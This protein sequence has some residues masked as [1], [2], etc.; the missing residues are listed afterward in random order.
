M[1]KRVLAIL[2]AIAMIASSC[3]LFAS[4]KLPGE[5]TY[6]QEKL[7]KDGWVTA[8][9]YKVHTVAVTKKTNPT[10]GSSSTVVNADNIDDLVTF[11]IDGDSASYSDIAA[12]INVNGSITFASNGTGTANIVFTATT[13]N[14]KE[15]VYRVIAA[16][17]VGAELTSSVVDTAKFESHRR[18]DFPSDITVT[19]IKQEIKLCKVTTGVHFY[20]KNTNNLVASEIAVVKATVTRDGGVLKSQTIS[21]SAYDVIYDLLPGDIVTLETYLKDKEAD[22][23]FYGFNCW[24][25]G[26]NVVLKPNDSTHPNIYSFKMD[27]KDVAVYANYVELVPRFTIDYDIGEHGK[28]VVFKEGTKETKTRAVFQGDDQISV[29]QGKDFTFTFIP[30]EGYEVSKVVIDDTTNVASFRYLFSTDF[31]SRVKEL[32][33]AT[34]STRAIADKA[35][36]EG[37]YTFKKVEKDH[38]IY[39]EFMK[40]EPLEAPSG[41]ELPTITAERDELAT[42]AAD[43]ESAEGG[44]AAGVV[45]TLPAENGAAAGGAAAVGGVVNPA[46]GSGSASIAVFAVMTI[47]A[48][49]AFVTMKKKED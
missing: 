16:A 34:G 1:N 45:T 46:T 11:K 23:G 10:V 33:A 3:A 14:Q 19:N 8:D 30:D 36:S 32:I 2:L 43:A 13:E 21:A 31:L 28:M 25:D 47:A 7:T 22:E 37:T 29:L 18:Y 12:Y 42:G 27:G 39:V 44:A 5:T 48:G 24:V 26:S 9:G 41:M 40:K 17:E 35:V 6:A 49:A 38:T 15:T 20:G 4:A